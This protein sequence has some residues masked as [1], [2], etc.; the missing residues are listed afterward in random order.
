MGGRHL[1]KLFFDVDPHG[2]GVHA[3]VFTRQAGKK[4][5]AAVL[6]LEARTKDVRNLESALIIYAG[7]LVASKHASPTDSTHFSPQIPTQILGEA[8]IVVNRKI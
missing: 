2:H 3:H 4:Q 8:R 1:A 5:L 7:L 6:A